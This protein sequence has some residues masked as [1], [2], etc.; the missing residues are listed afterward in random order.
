MKGFKENKASNL[1]N[2]RVSSFAAR[3][4]M[5]FPGNQ[6]SNYDPLVSWISAVRENYSENAIESSDNDNQD[7]DSNCDALVV[8]KDEPKHTR[9]SFSTG[10]ARLSY[11]KSNDKHKDSLNL[12]DT[13]T[14]AINRIPVRSV[15]DKVPRVKSDH[16]HLV[17]NSKPSDVEEK[18]NIGSVEIIELESEDEKLTVHS[19]EIMSDAESCRVSLMDGLSSMENGYPVDGQ[20][21][22]VDVEPVRYNPNDDLKEQIGYYQE[23][24]DRFLLK[25][26]IMNWEEREPTIT[27]ILSR[28]YLEDLASRDHRSGIKP[29]FFS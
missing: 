4:A 12:N 14:N 21:S 17:K 2:K 15:S 26:T 13:H 7:N 18:E 3:L 24:T 8:Y 23:Y 6:T 27:E 29:F 16:Q 11:M 25:E 9:Y 5:E 1:N 22:F 10:C 19:P 28:K 20:G